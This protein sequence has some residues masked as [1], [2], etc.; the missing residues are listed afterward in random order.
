MFIRIIAGR[1]INSSKN[2]YG[3]PKGAFLTMSET[4]SPA[5]TV[6][7]ELQWDF[8]RIWMASA[9][10]GSFVDDS[11]QA[12]LLGQLATAMYRLSPE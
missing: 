9:Q 12:A 6:S 5:N 11:S 3:F 1:A 2:N 4:R 7:M 8:I 10:P